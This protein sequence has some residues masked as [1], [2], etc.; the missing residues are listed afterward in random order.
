MPSANTRAA[1]RGTIRKAE[2]SPDESI[3]NKRFDHGLC[4]TCSAQIFEVT[5]TGGRRKLNPVTTPGVSKNGRCLYCHPEHET[6]SVKEEEE[7]WDDAAT[8]PIEEVETGEDIVDQSL[9]PV[10]ALDGYAKLRFV[11]VV[12]EGNTKKGKGIFHYVEET[13]KHKGKSIVYEGEFA[14]GFFE[15]RGSLRDQDGHSKITYDNDEEMYEGEM[16]N[17][18]RDGHGTYTWAKGIRYEGE[19]KNGTSHGNGKK[20]YKNGA[21][22]EGNWKDSKRD[23]QG[24]LRDANGRVKKVGTWK[25]D[26]FL[27]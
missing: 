15:G 22:Y 16:K 27:G 3:M 1:G 6:H 2:E 21:I 12:S 18:M 9:P 26:K 8:V 7:N 20:I 25:N 11:G 13:G 24:T 4:V 17:N 23:G 10:I 5:E 14:D 19:W